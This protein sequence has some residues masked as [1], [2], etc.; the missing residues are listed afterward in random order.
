MEK[1]NFQYIVGDESYC[2][3][4]INTIQFLAKNE[5][6]TELLSKFYNLYESIYGR[7]LNPSHAS[8]DLLMHHLNNKFLSEYN[9]ND[10]FDFYNQSGRNGLFINEYNELMDN[11]STM[12]TQFKFR[13]IGHEKLDFLT[14]SNH[15]DGCALY[16]STLSKLGMEETLNTFV[17]IPQPIRDNFYYK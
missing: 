4:D 16:S 11:I 10:R 9:E 1:L 3:Y 7:Y 8:I 14:P 6:G 5:H 13:K 17:D 15:Q 12:A 2:P